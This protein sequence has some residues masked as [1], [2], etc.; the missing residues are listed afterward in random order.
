MRPIMPKPDYGG[1]EI[2]IA[3]SQDEYQTLPARVK[4]D[5]ARLGWVEVLTA[6]ELTA[7]ERAA[8]L[9]GAPIML[10]IIGTPIRPFMLWVEGVEEE[11]EG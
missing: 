5:D 10:R 9:A 3:E 6:W 2:K 8:V 4:A 7:A 1:E 11:V